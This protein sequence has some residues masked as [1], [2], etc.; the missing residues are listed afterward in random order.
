M[1]WKSSKQQT[2]ADSTTETDYIAISEVIKKA[3]W[4]KKFIIKLEVIFEIEELVPVYCDNTGA[5]IHA[6][7]PRSHQRSK[8]I[9]RCFHLI[10]EIIERQDIAFE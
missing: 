10:R 5:V 7:E 3:V 2:V 1:S 6:K 4:M 8:H 9:F